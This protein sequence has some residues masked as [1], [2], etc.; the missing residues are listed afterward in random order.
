MDWLLFCEL[1]AVRWSPIIW[2]GTMGVYGIGI[3]IHAAILDCF[4]CIF[5]W[6]WLNKI[7]ST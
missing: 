3:G 5:E 1:P 7:H 6:F 4:L 2:A